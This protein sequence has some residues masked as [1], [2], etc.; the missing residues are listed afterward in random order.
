LTVHENASFGG[1]DETDQLTSGTLL[2]HGNFVQ[3]GN[4]TAFAAGSGFTVSMEGTAAQSIGFSNPD[5]TAGSSHF[6]NLQIA[7]TSLGGVTLNTNV[8]VEGQFSTADI[9]TDRYVFGAGNTLNAR[10]WSA[11]GTAGVA[12]LH[13]NN[14]PV[15]IR[16]GL[17][18]N[19]ASDVSFEGSYDPEVN[20]FAV[21]RLAGET[22]TFTNFT[23]P[24][25]TLG[26]NGHHV[27][28]Y[29]VGGTGPGLLVTMINP[30]PACSGGFMPGSL[31][32]NG[33]TLACP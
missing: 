15:V 29:Q 6:G 21:E 28:V 30:V 24:S 20:E 26:T 18:I 12:I 11:G 27:A 31:A 32:A 3:S 4:A 7:N 13:L 2:L 10:G 33:A 19:P 22:F 23:F 16:P 8:F 1:G 14:M 9:L 17:T 25:I 5:S